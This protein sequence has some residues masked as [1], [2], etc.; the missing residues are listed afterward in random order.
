M[1]GGT[2]GDLRTAARAA[3]SPPVLVLLSI[4]VLAGSVT[5]LSGC[6]RTSSTAPP[7]GMDVGAATSTAGATGTA[8]EGTA[9]A[10]DLSW[11]QG[12]ELPPKAALGELVEYGPEYRK[13]IALTFNAAESVK[14]AGFDQ[15]ILDILAREDCDATVFIT[16][17]WLKHNQAAGKALAARTG[18]ELANLSWDFP[19]FSELT[20]AEAASQVRRADELIE[21][22]TGRRPVLFRLP[23]GT[24]GPQTMLALRAMRVPAIEWDVV[25]GD[26]DPNVSAEAM[27][28]EILGRARSGSIVIMH[29][30]GRGVHTAEALPDII[31]GLREKGYDLVTVSALLR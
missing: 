18:I 4:I 1:T 9:P 23:Y 15:K 22:V 24:Y 29:I 30:N 8:Q 14:P 6:K 11:R 7:A 25:S 27:T 12:W 28:R 31:S 5:G 20:T 17:K 19:D 3:I 21:E 10:V 13:E 26:P 16:G 2:G